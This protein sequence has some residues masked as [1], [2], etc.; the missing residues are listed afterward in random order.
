MPVY[1]Q[2]ADQLI[3]AIQRGHLVA[4]LKLPGTRAF[5]QLLTVHR[6]TI[7]AV[8]EELEVQGWVKTLPNKGTVVLPGMQ[9]RP[10]KI[11][12]HQQA[13]VTAHPAAIS[14]IAA[15]RYPG[16]TGY[17]FRQTNILDNPFEYSDCEYVFNDGMPDTRLLQIDN[18]SQWYSA[19]LKRKSNQKKLAGYNQDG[20]EYFKANLCNYLNL[21]RG[22]HISGKNLLI[23]RSTEMSVYI[24]SRILL[25]EGDLVLVGEL[26][27]FSMNMIF[28]KNGAHIQTIPVDN[29]GIDVDSVQQICEHQQV[30]MIYITPHHHYPT[31]VTLSAQRRMRLLQLAAQYGFVIL[32]DDYDYDFHYNKAPMLPLLSADTAGMV[33]Y[34]GSFGKSLA[35]GFR[36]GFIVAPENLMTEMRKYLGIIDRQGD[37]LMEQ[38]LGQMIQ[39]GEIHRYL[40]KSMKVYQERRDNFAALLQQHLP[41]DVDF[42]I[43]SG[44]LAFWLRWKKR[45]NLLQLS[46]RCAQNNLFIPKTLLY[47]TQ[48]MAAMR[49]GF[50]HL[51]P[52]EMNTCIQIIRQHL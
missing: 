1:R 46:K 9:Q 18:L 12:P 32:E 40:R 14:P 13:A 5:S 48:S 19:N 11:L 10:V 38:A 24:T 34:T 50:G 20:S 43:P 4:G 2:I 8:Y 21:S 27:Y 41:E 6:N 22:L 51:T 26:S 52:E 16:A 49:V 37:I 47:Q 25:S 15:A 3:A 39:E 33:V 29:E 31:T 28:Q 30:R 45:P 35:P 44:G 17:T 42:T 36:T 23:T 7:V